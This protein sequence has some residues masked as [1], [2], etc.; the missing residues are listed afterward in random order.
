MSLNLNDAND[1][2]QFGLL[3][4]AVAGLICSLLVSRACFDDWRFSVKSKERLSIR[5]LAGEQ[6]VQE[7]GRVVIH[8]G[9]IAAGL[10]RLFD[11][12]S[13]SGSTPPTEGWGAV[14]YAIVVVIRAVLA[15]QSILR[16][17]SRGRI[18]AL[19]RA[20]RRAVRVQERVQGVA[21]GK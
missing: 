3:I 15:G 14:N 2:V 9:Y 19:E 18:L 1:Y 10:L 12:Y 7:L 4:L 21:H 5:Q 8:A 20:A 11:L 13:S 17:Y 6:Y 16:W